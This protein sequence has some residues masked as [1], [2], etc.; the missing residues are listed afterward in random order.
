DVR[1]QGT[2]SPG[3]KS[4]AG[5]DPTPQKCIHARPAREVRHPIGSSYGPGTTKNRLVA[6]S[7]SCSADR[8]VREWRASALITYALAA[9][10]RNG[11]N[12][13]ERPILRRIHDGC[14]WRVD[15]AACRQPSCD[16]CRKGT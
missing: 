5:T 12:R 8:A 13:L 10:E 7:E 3:L 14:A 15:S 9:T 16:M 4:A 2:A 11:A 6:R 1:D